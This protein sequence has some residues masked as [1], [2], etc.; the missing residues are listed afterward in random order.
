MYPASRRPSRKA[1]ALNEYVASDALFRKP[2]TGLDRPCP[3]AVN[4]CKIGA[5]PSAFRKRRRCILG[6]P[7]AELRSLNHVVRAQQQRLRDGDADGLRGL[8]VEREH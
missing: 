6:S 7:L 1:F 5:A 2:T 3:N 4:R 8:E